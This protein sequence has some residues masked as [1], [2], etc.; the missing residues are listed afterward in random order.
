MG[1]IARLSRQGGLISEAM[2]VTVV[3]RAVEAYATEGCIK[4][5]S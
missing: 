5:Q 3:R 2:D 4:P 1:S